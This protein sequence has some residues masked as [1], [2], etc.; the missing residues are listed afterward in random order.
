MNC[1]SFEMLVNELARDQMMEASLKGQALEH[2]AGCKPCSL[3]FD[4]ERELNDQLRELSVA[5]RSLGSSTD[6]EAQLRAEFRKA[7][8]ASTASVVARRR[9]VY[10]AVAALLLAMV[11]IAV[12]RSRIAPSTLDVG[13][14][15]DEKGA[16]SVSTPPVLA[17]RP[18]ETVLLQQ[19]PPATKPTAVRRTKSNRTPP[20]P[21]LET[22]A[23]VNSDREITTD[24]LPIG[25]TNPVSV[26]EGGQVVRV[27]LPRYAMARFG[28]PM[29]MERFNE[30]VKADVLMGVD[31]VPRAIRFVQ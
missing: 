14:G 25:Y 29:N 12:I 22:V 9:Y 8:T 27:E 20:T 10:A 24:F 13:I 18:V 30:R 5:M 7:R 3:R 19:Q 1:Q 2:S 21:V 16:Q 15:L 4:E 28:V 11:S 23:A 6:F 17:R 31:G 26:Q